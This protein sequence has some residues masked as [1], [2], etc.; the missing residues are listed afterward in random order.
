VA[1][2]H[3]PLL[4]LHLYT[5]LWLQHHPRALPAIKHK[6]IILFVCVCV[7]VCAHVHVYSL[8][9]VWLALKITFCIQCD[10]NMYYLSHLNYSSYQ[11]PKSS[12][13]QEQKLTTELSTC[14]LKI[15]FKFTN[16]VRFHCLKRWF[17]Q[18]Q[19]SYTSTCLILMFHLCTQ[20]ILSCRC[21]IMLRK[22]YIASI[23]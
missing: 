2:D 6:Q 14:F 9:A 22:E 21:E 15:P 7:C 20:I 12:S 16:Q 11:I 5:L 4:L 17:C 8:K 23:P 13:I 19:M 3:V 10:T 1:S 18:I